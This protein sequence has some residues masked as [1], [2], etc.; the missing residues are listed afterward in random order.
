MAT[1]GK[2]HTDQ[3]HLWHLEHIREFC[4]QN[5]THLMVTNNRVV[6]LQQEAS[7]QAAVDWWV[8]LTDQ[9]GEGMVVKPLDYISLHKGRIIQPAMKCRG[10]EYL[11]IVYGPEY[12]LGENRLNLK[13]RSIKTKRQ[14]AIQEF[15]LGIE[16]LRRFVDHAPLRK[17]HECVFG[18]LALES[19]GVDPR[20]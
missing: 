12:D 7:I 20:L 1:E 19:E 18:V 8:T 9:G 17:I 3:S 15:T 6:E 10:R 4:A 16:A 14:L 11:R 2:V 13:Q 5:P